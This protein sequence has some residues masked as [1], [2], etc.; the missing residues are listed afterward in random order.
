MGFFTCGEYQGNFNCFSDLLMCARNMGCIALQ[1][2]M[3]AYLGSVSVAF[4]SMLNIQH[5]INMGEYNP[6]A[7]KLLGT[8]HP[9]LRGFTYL[10]FNTSFWLL[11]GAQGGGTTQEQ[12]HTCGTPFSLLS[13]VWAEA[14]WIPPLPTLSLPWWLLCPSS[15]LLPASGH[16]SLLFVPPAG[17]GSAGNLLLLLLTVMNY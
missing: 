15:W 12:L 4:Y 9:W 3:L 13:S 7:R 6:V 11:M 5:L 10:A 1:L 17:H 16:F 2:C 14:R 8:Q